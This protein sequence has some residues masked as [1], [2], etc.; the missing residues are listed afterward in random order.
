M[1]VMLGG[2]VIAL[3][4]VVQ[5]LP[6]DV[7]F[8]EAVHVA[9]ALGRMNVVD[10]S[11]DLDNR[12]N[13]WSGITGGLFLALAYFGTDQSQVQRYLSGRSIT[14]ARLGL[15]FNGLLKIPMQFLILF[16]GAMVFV[17]YQFVMPPVFFN[18]PA[19]DQVLASEHAPAMQ[20]VELEWAQAFEAKRAH[21]HGYLDALDTGDAGQIEQAKAVLQ[22]SQ[23]EST[24]LRAK[25]KDV[26]KAALPKAETKDSDYIFITFVLQYLPMGLVGLL[27][28]VI[29]SAA[30]S[31]TAS[32][33]SALGSTTMVDFYRRSFVR[34]ASDRHYL[35]VSK[36]MTVFWGALAVA[37][38]TFASLLDNLIQAVNILGSIF[39]GT[40]L[41]I[42]LAAFFV[43]HV[44]GHSVFLAALV[45][46][47]VV[48][49]LFF[50][51]DIGF[52]WYNVIGCGLVVALS[53]V[54]EPLIP[55]PD[56]KSE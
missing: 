36:V 48:V 11:F 49:V 15:L 20:A 14:Q 53:S 41:G 8:G 6:A 38:A 28:A 39:Y 17:F 55:G 27:L 10:F 24:A 1:V 21:V 54:L 9:G 22:A 2:M 19:R 37:F 43:K 51:S 29:L 40:V 52:L 13:F 30:M 18:A 5:N 44:R 56:P 47:A 23:A 35:W 33:L 46:Q 42:F 50:Q 34:D 12:Y 25:A 45:S 4:L 31:S 32:E 7:G 3:V 16:I 26:V